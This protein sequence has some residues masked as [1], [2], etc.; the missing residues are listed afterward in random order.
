MCPRSER[1]K[2]LTRLHPDPTDGIQA[3]KAGLESAGFSPEIHDL[4]YFQDDYG[5][6]PIDEDDEDDEDEDE[7]EDEDEDM[8]G[9]E[10]YEIVEGHEDDLEES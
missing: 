9:S 7:N 1:C 3:I 6:T 2:C 5:L 10:G 8:E 4:N